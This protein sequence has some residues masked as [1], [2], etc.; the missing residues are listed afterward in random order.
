MAGNPPPNPHSI[1]ETWKIEKKNAKGGP[2][3][4]SLD[5]VET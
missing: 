2:R 3:T 4:F 1:R 5:K